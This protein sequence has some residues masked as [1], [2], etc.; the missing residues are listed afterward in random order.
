M[1]LIAGAAWFLAFALFVL[2]YGPILMREMQT[3]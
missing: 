3:D 1:L 2:T